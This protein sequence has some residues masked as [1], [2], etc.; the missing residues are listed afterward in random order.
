[1]LKNHGFDKGRVEH[2]LNVIE[3]NAKMQHQLV[4]DLRDVSR[5]VAGKL[6]LVIGSVGP[7]GA[8]EAAL[9]TLR[10][11]LDA[12]RVTVEMAL[13]RDTGS[14]AGDAARLQWGPRARGSI[15]ARG[16]PVRLPAEPEPLPPSV[17]PRGDAEPAPAITLNGLRILFVDDNA[18]TREL[19]ETMLAERGLM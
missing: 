8:C 9:D 19:V 13:D 16:S 7:T 17:A 6:D 10:P 18:D 1:M 4:N 14:I 15:R 5:I 12:K 3:R 2:G 11:Q